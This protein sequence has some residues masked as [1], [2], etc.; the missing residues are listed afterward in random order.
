MNKTQSTQFSDHHCTVSEQKRL[1]SELT[2][3][4][5]LSYSYKEQYQC[6]LDATKESRKN[7]ACMFS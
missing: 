6:Y 7:K 1:V 5:R 2:R 3:C 4:D